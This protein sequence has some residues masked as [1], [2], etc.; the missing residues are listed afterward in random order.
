MQFEK[1]LKIAV[2]GGASD[3]ILKVGAI[4]RFRLD[5]KLV[6]LQGG[7]IVTHEVMLEWLQKMVPNHLR[8]KINNLEDLDFSFQIGNQYRFR[9][10]V[11]RQSR[12]FAMVLRVI[13]NHIR[14]LDELQLPPI[15]TK[16][17]REKRGLILVTGATGSGKSTTLASMIEKINQKRPYHIITIEDPI[18]YTYQEKRSTINQREIGLDTNDFPSALRSS[19]RQDPDVILVGELRDQVTVETTLKAA[20]TGHMVFSTL[21]TKDAVETLT[22]IKSFFPPH[23]HDLIRLSL[24]NSL[25]AVVSQRLIPRKDRD[26]MVPALE[27]LVMN[28]SI[29]DVIVKGNYSEITDIIKRDTG[30]TG[31]QTFDQSLLQ[32]VQRGTISESVA[33]SNASNP[34]DFQLSLAGVS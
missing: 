14:T 6:D 10:N 30:N 11:F 32:L 16:L 3:I 19:L 7:D 27:I 21:H 8:N 34:G 20:E 31:M 18:E 33:L 15:I 28:T 2:K 17:C 22:R 12:K 24:A 1:I 5:T 13:N 29:Q 23:Q 4:P 26:G 25:K 9:I